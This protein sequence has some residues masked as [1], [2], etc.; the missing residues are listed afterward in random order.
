MNE[1]SQKIKVSSYRDG[2]VIAH[3]GVKSQEWGKRRYQ[4]EDGSLTPLG[5]IHY[6]VGKKREESKIKMREEKAAS[7][8]E[9][10]V[11]KAQSKAEARIIRERNKAERKL[12]KLQEDTV[13][14][15]NREAADVSREQIQ[16]ENKQMD[17]SKAL[18]ITA[19][20]GGVSYGIYKFKT[21]KS[22]E[23]AEKA[24][25]QASKANASEYAKKGKDII[26]ATWRDAGAPKFNGEVV[27]NAA[28]KASRLIGGPVKSKGPSVVD[29]TWREVGK[30]LPAVLRR[31]GLKRLV[32]H[33]VNEMEGMVL[34][35]TAKDNGHVIQHYGI[36][37]QK[38]GVRRWQY[39]DGSLTPEGRAH[40]GRLES[41]NEKGLTKM[42]RSA[43]TSRS[44]NVLNK[45]LS[46]D[47]EKANKAYEKGNSEKYKKKAIDALE[48]KKQLEN[49]EDIK[50]SAKW[51][52]KADA[53][54][55]KGISSSMLLATG[56]AVATNP[57]LAISLLVAS[58]GAGLAGRI[59]QIRNSSKAIDSWPKGLDASEKDRLKNMSVDE[60]KRKMDKEFTRTENQK[61][62]YNLGKG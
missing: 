52:N 49:E 18:A 53:S 40:Y 32:K 8:A 6:G 15:Q 37:G 10:R 41:S 31:S 47:V 11:I 36:K 57:A 26:D 1:E 4:Y 35:A 22:S 24:I 38:W 14:E 58:A 55:I 30:D 9:A 25:K 50:E 42:A 20:I 62:I 56:A 3:H 34:I 21:G 27:G 60:L 2:N 33:G 5:R 16:A 23:A 12:A 46:K 39:E 13:R 48:T 28:S 44:V 61:K 45:R 17:F 54:M 7:K 43:E 59:G 51:S 19:L 29:G